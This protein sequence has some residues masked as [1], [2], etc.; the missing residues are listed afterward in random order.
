MAIKAV[1]QAVVVQRD[2]YPDQPTPVSTAL[3][4][5]L[6][7]HALWVGADSAPV[8]AQ[9]RFPPDRMTSMRAW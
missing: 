1:S 8:G 9:G 3:P 5:G 6:V 4:M 2:G 7:V